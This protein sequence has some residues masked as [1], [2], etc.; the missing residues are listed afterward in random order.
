M[1]CLPHRSCNKGSNTTLFYGDVVFI[2]K[3]ARLIQ[4]AEQILRHRTGVA[5]AQHASKL[6]FQITFRVNPIE[7]LQAGD[8]WWRDDELLLRIAEKITNKEARTVGD[9]GKHDVQ[10][11]SQARENHSSDHQ[12]DK[13]YRPAS[14]HMQPRRDV[15]HWML[16]AA[17]PP[18]F[19]S[20]N[21]PGVFDPLYL[22]QHPG[23]AGSHNE[24]VIRAPMGIVSGPMV[25]C[26]AL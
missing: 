16:S 15:F 2:L 8:E 9:R 22:T 17:V 1:G 19:A 13:M 4:R 5:G 25:L 26:V 6:A 18:L 7:E 12:T 20:V 11:S 14:A 10:I 3:K 24:T 21:H 23:T